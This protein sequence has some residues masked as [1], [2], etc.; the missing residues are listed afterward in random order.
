[1]TWD[2][3]TVEE[4]RE[5]VSTDLADS[6]VQRLLDGTR[7]SILWTYG[8]VEPGIET[9]DG[10]QSYIFLRYAAASILSVSEVDPYTGDEVVLDASDYWLRDDRVSILRL[11]GGANSA[12]VWSSPVLVTYETP[13]LDAALDLAQIALAELEINHLPGLTSETIGAWNE[14]A[15]SGIPYD[16]ERAA[17][18]AALPGAGPPPPG[19]A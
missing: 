8:G 3:L 17:I 18:L 6:A 19:F 15:N 5:H 7:A 1:M 11:A 16:Q 9:H 2:G 14:Q 10:G 13:D 4:F 12:E